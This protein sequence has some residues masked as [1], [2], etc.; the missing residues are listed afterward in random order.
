MRFLVIKKFNLKY[1]Q[2]FKIFKEV[3]SIIETLEDSPILVIILWNLF[4]TGLIHH[5]QIET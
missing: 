5:M 4:S 3:K 2:I 1:L